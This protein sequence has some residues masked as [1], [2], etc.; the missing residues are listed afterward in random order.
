MGAA[1]D[2]E[3]IGTG[4]L[5]QP[6]NSL[7]TLGFLV[8][9]AIIVTR[10]PDRRW[11]GIGVIGTGVGSFLFHGPM[12]TGA[13]WAHDL[14]LAWLLAMAAAAGSRWENMSRI[15]ALIALGILFATAPALADPVAVGLTAVTVFSLLRHDRSAAT[16]GPLLLLGAVAIFG[17][18]GATSGPLCEPGSMFQPHAVWHL[19]AAVAVGWWAM[20][21]SG[22]FAV[23]R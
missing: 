4:F 11:I 1:A 18:L 14:T 21:S 23:S 2:C 3:T 6:I 8:V 7:T 10:R 17:R 19:G 13:E 22:Q 12:P 20:S 15:P 9:G 5:G 16:L